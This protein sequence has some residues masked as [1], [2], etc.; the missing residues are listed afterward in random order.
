MSTLPQSRCRGL[1]TDLIQRSV[2]LA[3]CL[4]YKLAKTEATGDYSRFLTIQWK[5]VYD[6]FTTA[7]HR[8]AFTRAGFTIVAEVDY[9]DFR[10]GGETSEEEEE[11]AVFGD[12]E[13]H[14]GVALMVKMLD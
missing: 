2:A 3:R 9:K 8:R 14:Q 6:D 5:M 12:M 4:G 10:V 7:N 11:A 13:G 1:A